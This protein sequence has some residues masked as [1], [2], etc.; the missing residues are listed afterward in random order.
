MTTSVKVKS[1]NYPALVQTFDLVVKNGGP[2]EAEMVSER[3]L[4]PKDGDVEFFC[5]TTRRL[6]ITDVGYDHPLIPTA[7]VKAFPGGFWTVEA[8]DDGSGSECSTFSGLN[9]E[10]RAKAYAVEKYGWQAPA[11]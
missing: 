9:A 4:R 11:A 7:D 2:V 10:A 5:T 8:A 1:A 3:V 6:V